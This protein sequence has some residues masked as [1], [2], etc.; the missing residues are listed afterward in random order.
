MLQWLD[1][2]SPKI[3][4]SRCLILSTKREQ[5]DKLPIYS[6][7]NRC[8]LFEIYYPLVF[9]SVSFSVRNL[10]IS[11]LTFRQ[12]YVMQVLKY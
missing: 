11:D 2:L 5:R 8:K 6:G 1:I 9:L 4:R 10:L 3:G 7:L 12:I